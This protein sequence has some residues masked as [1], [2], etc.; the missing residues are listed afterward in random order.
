MGKQSL[1]TKYVA[2]TL[3]LAQDLNTEETVEEN[4]Q[5]ILVQIEDSNT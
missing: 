4:R 2:V 3:S 5:Q 1:Y